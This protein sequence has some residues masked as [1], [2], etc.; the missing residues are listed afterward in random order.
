VDAWVNGKS[1]K[2]VDLHFLSFLLSLVLSIWA[3]DGWKMVRII[4]RDEVL[5]LFLA[6][7]YSPNS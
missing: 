4:A 6:L 2:H 1:K 7:A 5:M 3:S